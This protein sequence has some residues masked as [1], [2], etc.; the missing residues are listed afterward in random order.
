[1][2]NNKMCKTVGVA[3]LVVLLLTSVFASIANTWSTQNLLWGYGDYYWFRN[4]DFTSEND[5]STN[6]DWPVSMVFWGPDANVN[7][8][9]FVLGWPYTNGSHMKFHYYD[10][11]NGYDDFDEDGGV[12]TDPTDM[13]GWHARIYGKPGWDYF[14]DDSVGF[15]VLATT[16]K[17][18][19][20]NDQRYGYT[21]DAAYAGLV[22][23]SLT[24]GTE[25]VENHFS[26]LYNYESYRVQS[27]FWENHVWEHD[28]WARGVYIDYIW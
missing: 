15:Y 20:S 16:H 2:K 7:M 6:V 3:L 14:Y 4:Y 1:M 5:S 8:A 11:L 23:A 24:V 21:S 10:V 13:N 18:W 9:K 25:N 12:K 27:S 26:Y 17:D 22:Y 19:Y 28:G